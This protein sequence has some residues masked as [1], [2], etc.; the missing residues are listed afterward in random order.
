MDIGGYFKKGIALAMLKG[1][2]AEEVAADEEAFV[3]ALLFIAFPGLLG[4]AV[5]AVAVTAMGPM[6]MMAAPFLSG[7]P[8]MML[9][10]MFVVF[11]LT[12]SIF[13]S[14]ISAGLWHLIATKVFKGEAK[15]LDYYQTL[16]IGGLVAWGGMVP[17]IGFLFS[18][19]SI[20]V[21]IVITKSVYGLSTG[22]AVAVILLPVLL[23][24]VLG[25]ALA[26][27]VPVMLMSGMG[28]RH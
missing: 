1:E 12:A 27:L 23:I 18:I 13:G 25:I 21:S 6:L 14:L 2:V 19:W 7:V 5:L 9:A 15:F 3:P 11:G 4:G 24:A 8:Y 28:M 16:G 17:Y 20:M 26:V 22:K 10:F